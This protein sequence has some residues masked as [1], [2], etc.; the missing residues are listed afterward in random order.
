[1][2]LTE[3]LQLSS[4]IYAVNGRR[5]EHIY[6][7]ALW[8]PVPDL[9]GEERRQ[10]CTAEAI[11]DRQRRNQNDGALDKQLVQSEATPTGLLNQAFGRRDARMMRTL[12]PKAPCRVPHQVHVAAD[13]DLDPNIAGHLK[14]QTLPNVP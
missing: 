4:L 12:C 5:C 14:S 10:L 6:R 3:T 8:R 13:S 9:L 2:K 7:E 1:M 11:R